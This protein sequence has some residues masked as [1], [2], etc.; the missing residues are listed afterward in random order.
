MVSV[1]EVPLLP[2]YL[3]ELYASPVGRPALF[4]VMRDAAL[5]RGDAQGVADVEKLAMYWH[6]PPEEWEWKRVTPRVG[7]TMAVTFEISAEEI[8]SIRSKGQSEGERL[9]QKYIRQAETRLRECGVRKLQFLDGEWSPRLTIRYC[10]YGVVEVD[11]G[12]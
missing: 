11:T 6:R 9:V 4:N 10:V 3:A 2:G 7:Q 12:L 5:D 1:H 8:I